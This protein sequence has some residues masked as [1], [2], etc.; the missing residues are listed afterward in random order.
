MTTTVSLIGKYFHVPSNEL[1]GTVGV[2][3]RSAPAATWC[4]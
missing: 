1:G 3:G 4:I 2:F